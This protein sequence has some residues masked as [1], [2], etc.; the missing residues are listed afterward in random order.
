MV[1]NGI[2]DPDQLRV[3]SGV[4]HSHCQKHGIDPASSEG[5]AVARQIM[6]LFTA[7]ARSLL[8]LERALEPP[9]RL[10]A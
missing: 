3:I 1:F 9:S 5:E 7:G 10:S 6:S 8:D 4:F 2:V